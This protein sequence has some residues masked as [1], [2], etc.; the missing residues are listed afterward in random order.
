MARICP[1]EIPAIY[2]EMDILIQGASHMG[3][4]LEGRPPKGE[5]VLPDVCF[6]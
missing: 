1:R 6:A 3:A 5:S 2:M 4:G